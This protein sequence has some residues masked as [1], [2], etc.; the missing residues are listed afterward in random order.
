MAYPFQST[1]NISQKAGL[2]FARPFLYGLIS[3]IF[4]A[5]VYFVPAIYFRR[6]ARGVESSCRDGSD[7]P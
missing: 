3:R 4:D 2:T 1:N 5:R 7:L 6:R